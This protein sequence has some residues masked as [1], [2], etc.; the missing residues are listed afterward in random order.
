MGTAIRPSSAQSRHSAEGPPL[1][2]T[3][4]ISSSGASWSQRRVI[5]VGVSILA[6]SLAF[7]FLPAIPYNYYSINIG[8]G[9]VR[10][11]ANVSPSFI[12]VGCGE[13]SD[14]TVVAPGASIKLWEGPA[15]RCK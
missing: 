8:V 12:A 2:L 9:G 10:V 11:S 4:A 5:F 13:V 6:L 15:W 7:F 3:G 14:P 1:R